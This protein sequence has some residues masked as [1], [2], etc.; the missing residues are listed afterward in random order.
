MSDELHTTLRNDTPV[1]PP[2]FPARPIN[3]GPLDKAR[4]KSGSWAC[5]P[6]VNGWRALVHVPTS[7]M[8]NRRGERLS[9]K[10]Q[11]EPALARLCSTL[12]AEAFEWADCEA[13]ERRHG[14]GRGSLIVLDAIPSR[15]HAAT[16]YSERRRWLEA[17]LA[18][19]IP[20]ASFEPDSIYLVPSYPAEKTAELWEFLK[21]CNCGARCDFYEGVVMKRTRAAYPAQLI[22]ADRET[23]DWVKHRWHF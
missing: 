9:I 8:W 1:K 5:E 11:F 14:I 3:G 22:S 19:P 7:F 16:P 18:T 23:T 12:N 2:T 4:P 10:K 15:P 13:L 17:V 6:K 20:P 21:E